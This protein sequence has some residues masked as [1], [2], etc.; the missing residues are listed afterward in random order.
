MGHIKSKLKKAA[1]LVRHSEMIPIVREVDREKTLAGKNALVLGGSGGIG[2]AIARELHSS[3]AKVVLAGTNQQ[4]LEQN[5][6]KLGGEGEPVSWTRIDLSDSN[7]IEDAMG[8]SANQF[9]VPD[10]FVCSSGVHT[11]HVD[12]WSVTPEEFDRV[13][14]IN[15]RGAFFSARAAACQM[16]QN[17]IK[18]HILFVGSSRGFEPAWSPY[19]LSKWGLRGLTRGLAQQLLPMGIVVNGIAPGSTATPLIGVGDGDDIS[20]HENEA[21]RLVTPDE[22]AEWARMLVGPQGDMIVGEMILVSAGRG[23]VDIR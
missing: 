14:G 12:F 10:I 9:G 7:S 5:A 8:D 20:S 22:I 18:G 19:G 2:Y 16:M 3:G 6:R 11:E 23:C 21:G 15:L 13:I 1:G 17:N 4:K